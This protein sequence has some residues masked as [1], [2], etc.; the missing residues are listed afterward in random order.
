MGELY[1]S[2]RL[3]NHASMRVIWNGS[4][5]RQAQFLKIC[6]NLV[7]MFFAKSEYIIS[8]NIPSKIIILYNY[9]KGLQMNTVSH[10]CRGLNARLLY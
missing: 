3:Q 6:F 1:T 2:F 10:A 4:V 7:K 5:V 9:I 8:K